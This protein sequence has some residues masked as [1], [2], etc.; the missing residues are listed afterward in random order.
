MQVHRLGSGHSNIPAPVPERMLKA[1]VA[2][3]KM[4]TERSSMV[5]KAFGLGKQLA[6]S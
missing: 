6:T 4:A 2:G 3:S 1:V 5:P